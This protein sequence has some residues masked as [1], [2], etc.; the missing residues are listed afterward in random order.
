MVS[1]NKVKNMKSKKAKA[2]TFRAPANASEAEL[3]L[4]EENELRD[5]LGFPPHQPIVK[6]PVAHKNK[7]RK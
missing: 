7:R 2:K 1:T 3:I 4:Q 6:K 5:L